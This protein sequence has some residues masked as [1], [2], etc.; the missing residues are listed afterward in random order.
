MPAIPVLLKAL[1]RD[2]FIVP[3]VPIPIMV[4]VV[5][6]PTWVYIKIETWDITIITP[7]PVIIMGAIPTTFPWTPPPTIPEKY[8]Y[9]ISIRNNVDIVRIRHHYDSWWCG[10]YDGWWQRNSNMYIYPCH[11]W[12]GNDNYQRQKQ[13]SE[14]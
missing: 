2:S 9:I 4:S 13:C 3:P 12:N 8:V 14:K 5:S 6:S 11:R 1:V 7:T 10:K